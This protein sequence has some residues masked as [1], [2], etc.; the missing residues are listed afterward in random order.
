MITVTYL[1]KLNKINKRAKQLF[2]LLI[3]GL[4]LT[5]CSEA[6][7][8]ISTK[9]TP[10][11]NPDQQT[12]RIGT[13]PGDFADM[14]RDYIGPELEK[15]GYQVTL[16]EITDIVIP[17][18]G[19]H[20][21][22]LEVNIFQHKPYLDEFNE[23]YNA[24]LTPIV[25]V[26]TAP[27]GLYG[28]KLHSLD[29]VKEGAT[30]G[31]PSNVTNFS[32]GLRILE[33][34]GWITLKEDIDFFRVRKTDITSNPKNLK[35]LEIEAAQMVRARQDVDYAVINGNFAQD[36]GIP[37]T[38]ALYIEPS[39]HF[40]NWVVVKKADSDTPWAKTLIDIINSDGFKA[41]TQAHFPGYN[42]PL[43]W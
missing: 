24:M 15:A 16:K 25:Q 40:V 18:T 35:I 29:S 19:V 11:T 41:Y 37:F 4:V 27:F 28:G 23:N 43:S 30:I 1:K 6:E 32:R 34:L 33:A 12:I 38:D 26:P 10:Q 8:D 9:A 20:E 13:S 39:K 31:I 22:S 17:N 3:A 7:S 14:V 2:Y 5:A 42:L 36:A 21:G